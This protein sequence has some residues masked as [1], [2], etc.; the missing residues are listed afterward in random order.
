MDRTRTEYELTRLDSTL[1]TVHVDMQGNCARAM[2]L[3][4]IDEGVASDYQ[5]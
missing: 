1:D 2:K 5:V 3:D 4:S